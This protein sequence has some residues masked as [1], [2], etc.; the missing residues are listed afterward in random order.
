MFLLTPTQSEEARDAIISA[1]T[2]PEVH[3]A[4]NALYQDLQNQID[5]RR[6]KCILSGRCCRFDEF[7]HRLYVTTLEMAK[8][9]HDLE[10]L[11]L[12]VPATNPS[13]CP[14]QTNKLCSVH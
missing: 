6:P 13:G 1:S 9:V 11:N 8:F 4:V 12:A 3:S 10:Q 7:G 2:R 14:F 5:I